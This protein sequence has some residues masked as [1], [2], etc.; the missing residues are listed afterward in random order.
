M[1]NTERIQANN[2]N[3]REALDMANNLPDVGGTAEIEE[4]DITFIDYDGTVLH[5][6]SFSEVTALTELPPLPE[7]EGLIC[8]GWNWDLADIQGYAARQQKMYVGAM[9]ITDDGKTRVYIS[10]LP[11]ALSPQVRFATTGTVLVDWGDGSDTITVTG[12]SAT[13]AKTITHDYAE[14]GDYIITYEVQS[15]AMYLLG[16]SSGGAYLM[17]SADADHRRNYQYAVRKVELGA[18]TYCN[19]NYGFGYFAKMETITLPDGLPS[20]GAGLLNYC[21]SLKSV[22]TPKTVSSEFASRTSWAAERISLSKGISAIGSNGLRD[23]AIHYILLP[24]GLQSIG[25]Y[26]FYTVPLKNVVIPESVEAIDSFAFS[27]CYLMETVTISNGAC[28]IAADA[29]ANCYTVQYF[30]FTRCKSVPTLE[31]VDAFDNLSTLCEFR[32]PANLYDE[33]IAAT[34]WSTYAAQI[35]PVRMEG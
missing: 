22:T 26:A 28:T 11:N 6:Y 29:F 7:Q 9:Y 10:L 14:A 3:L 16:S 31:S 33:W 4:K 18:N 13:S 8:Q 27:A 1:T 23:S 21:Y 12:T 35:V 19:A 20:L 24:D 15:G 30:D 17:Y 2:A 25:S 34:N 32:V 5:S